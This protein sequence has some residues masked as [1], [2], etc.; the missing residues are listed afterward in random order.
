M[1]DLNKIKSQLM[2]DEGV[3]LYVYADSEGI[4]TCGIGHEVLPS[5][6][7]HMGDVITQQSCDNF[8]SQDLQNAIDSCVRAQYIP[9]INQPEMVQE[10]LVNLVF[11]MGAAELKSFITF[12]TFL[13]N[14]RYADAAND[15]LNTKWATQVGAR[16]QRIANAIASCQGQ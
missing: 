13:Y 4:S 10:S 2:Y 16:A 6:N 7:L 11:N 14:R 15:L 1:M 5:D 12:L 8:F 9:Y 3:K